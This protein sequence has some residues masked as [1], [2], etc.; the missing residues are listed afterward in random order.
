MSTSEQSNPM[1]DPEPLTVQDRAGRTLVLSEKLA[2]GKNGE[3]WKSY[4][5]TPSPTPNNSPSLTDTA[6]AFVAVKRLYSNTPLAWQKLWQ[7]AQAMTALARLHNQPAGIIRLYDLFEYPQGQPTSQIYLVMEYCP[8]AAGLKEAGLSRDEILDCF[9]QMGRALEYL[10]A[11][12]ILHRDIKPHN[13]LLTRDDQNRPIFKLADFGQAFVPASEGGSAH[14]LFGSI[15]Y[16]APE[17][18][19]GAVQ[20]GPSADLYSLAAVIY[21]MLVG[22][23]YLPFTGDRQADTLLVTE[24]R[25]P[26]IAPQSVL[27]GVFQP[28]RP[29]IG[30]IIV[31]ALSLLPSERYQTAR[32][33]VEAL[34]GV[35]I[36]D[37]Y[38]LNTLTDRRT[39]PYQQITVQGNLYQF[40]GDA[41]VP[42]ASQAGSPTSSHAY[43]RPF[44]SPPLPPQGI[45]GRE[46]AMTK[47]F[48]LLEL[49]NEAAID[50]PPVALL[51]MGGIGKTTLTT[52]L[53][54]L[55]VVPRLFPDGVLWVELGATPVVRSS[56]LDWGDRVGL[57][58]KP[59][60]DEAVCSSQLRSFLYDRRMLVIVDDV[61]Q[62]RQGQAFQVGGPRSRLLYTTR[63]SPIAYDLA[64]RERTLSVNLLSPVA[65]LSLLRRLA[66]EAVATNPLKALRLCEKLEFL[67]LALTLAGRY[68]A[69]ETDL[70][71][72]RLE[73]ALDELIEQHEVRLLQLTDRMG[74]PYLPLDQPASLWDVLGRS[75][76]R[77]NPTDRERFAI[78]S[79]FKAE[80]NTWD[81]NWAGKVWGCSKREAEKTVGQFMARGLVARRGELI[82]MHALLTDYATLLKAQM[83]L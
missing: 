77:L 46:E 73:Q 24:R 82:W 38:F 3:V 59:V 11:H 2:G 30:E 63:E 12:H 74:R 78:S 18:L 14:N 6:P 57:D 65:S 19:T 55:E 41:P 25:G 45:I 23:S 15:Q 58:L 27:K 4:Y 13:I 70:G 75:V 48:E 28:L 81:V 49:E 52:A 76:D 5:T 32:E 66:A 26:V 50:L 72:S 79:L 40:Y 71:T 44:M 61:W 29:K 1:P 83:K 9:Y 36:G 22:Q 34:E 51:G 37:P 67:P 39:F 68:L 47:L 7:E 42:S 16:A 80:P 69:V 62:T 17:L 8:S 35:L 21:E 53:S 60:V 20:D 31:K 10:H 54:R 43:L 33:L 64:T 56:L